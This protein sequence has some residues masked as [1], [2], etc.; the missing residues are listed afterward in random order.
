MARWNTVTAM[1]G[2]EALDVLANI[3][4]FS[5]LSTRQIRRL[6]KGSS[7]DTYEAGTTIVREGGH[8][9]SL[10]II[11]EGKARIERDGVEISQRGPGEFF[12]EVSM[13]DGRVRSASVIAATPITCVV[14]YRDA[15][16]KLV[17][18]EPAAAWTL[19]QS[20][21]ARLRGE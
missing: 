3:P 8:S 18:S 9:T 13:I 16:H 19:L 7:Q 20:L 17:L 12:G 5:K 1:A 11:V 21:A 15:L 6:L 2:T 10:F 14:V 4:L